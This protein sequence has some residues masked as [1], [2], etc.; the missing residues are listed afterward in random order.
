[1][2]ESTYGDRHRPPRSLDRFADAIS[3]TIAR[4]GTVLIPA[5]AV[6]RTPVLLAA[7]RDY[8]RRPGTP[9][10]GVRGQPDGPA[11]PRRVP[12]CRAR[13]YRRHPPPARLWRDG[14]FAVGALL[15]GVI[16][17]AYGLPAA[18]WAVATLTAASGLLV[19]ARMYETHAPTPETMTDDRQ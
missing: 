4:S 12:L 14:G 6:D 19:T 8:G 2:V 17:D 7:L 9:G 15:T 10:A 16:A 11:R 5:F 13:R 18:I 3:R 1:V